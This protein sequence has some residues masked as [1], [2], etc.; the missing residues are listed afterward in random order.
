MS[1]RPMLVAAGCAAALALSGC[2]STIEGT[3]QAASAPLTG[4]AGAVTE[5]APGAAGDPLTLP[6]TGDGQPTDGSGTLVD[7]QG[8]LDGPGGTDSLDPSALAQLLGGLTARGADGST[9]LGELGA[10]LSPECLSLTGISMALGMMTLL[11]SLGQPLTSQDVDRALSQISN[12]PPELKG[13]VAT[14]TDAARKAA[15]RSPADAARILSA[16][17][18]NAA[19]DDISH[20]LDSRC[21][22]G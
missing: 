6:S 18:V 21:A 3:P 17:A 7:P 13:A 2:A 1:F 19:L 11:P 10:L 16:P 15:G 9:G 20:Y 22:Q 14:L 4:A 12:V 8:L 5:P